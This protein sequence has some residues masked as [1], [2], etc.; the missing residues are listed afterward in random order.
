[1]SVRNRIYSPPHLTNYVEDESR[2][3][4]DRVTYYHAERARGGVGLIVMS[5][6]A[7]HPSGVAWGLQ[8][9]DER[10]I[11][12]LK[13][14][15]SMV[16]EHGSKIIQLIHTMGSNALHEYSRHAAWAPSPKK[17][18]MMTE[19]P[20]EMEGEEITHL[21]KR[22]GEVS[23]IIQEAGYDGIELQ[24]ALGLIH[25][26][27]SPLSNQR[28]DEYGGNLENRMRFVNEVINSI[29]K[30]C[31]REIVL[32]VKICADELTPGGITL[33]DAKEIARRLDATGKLDYLAVR[34]G[35]FNTLPI[36]IG[37]MNVPQG[38]AVP[39]GAAIKKV[40]T[41]PVFTQLRIKNPVHAEKIL[42]DGHADMVG[43]VRQLL[44]DPELPNKAQSGDLEGIR[45]CMAC[46]QGCMHRLFMN[47]PIECVQNPA[48]G[49]ERECG[50]GFI[51]IANGKKK[52]LIVGGGPAGLKCAEMAAQR[53]HRI[54]LYERENELGGQ[55][56]VAAK[57]FNRE[58]FR[59]VI[60]Y[61]EYRVKEL[62][63][64]VKSG[65]EATPEIVVE[66][67]PDAV[68][69]A[70]GSIPTMLS[71]PGE[72]QK[73]VFNVVQVLKGEVAV[74]ENV[75]VLDCGE[76]HWKYA[77]IV[78]YLAHKGHKVYA[79]TPWFFVGYSLPPIS[80]PTLYMRLYEKNVIINPLTSIK[81]I[82]GD[83]VTTFNVISKEEKLLENIDTVILATD[84][85]PDVDLYRKLKEKVKELY[86]IGDCV[87]PRKVDAAI[88]EGFNLG[89]IL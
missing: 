39:Y 71:L 7:L 75:V 12:H 52:L 56:H 76:G 50:S 70:T 44:C 31:G 26:F 43:M 77:S 69:I 19:V 46:N 87:A 13:R 73:N 51:T 61:L 3:W 25:N 48:S 20:H 16:H 18:F 28:K 22:Y 47:L 88:R 59:E 84:N 45:Y 55:V 15:T 40:V 67:A 80:V 38:M 89:R 72:E 21:I 58:E 79:L 37:D 33:D 82:S 36:F 78:E 32:G 5:E 9:V 62:K 64:E 66:E 8:V 34:I 63:V 83:I 85:Q 41:V 6:I 11:P 4:W 57:V 74:G 27:L 60:N 42:A 30:R 1:M 23:H 65:L 54:I 35:N 53:G 86:L 10:H 29:R 24:A 81:E 14:L 2:G 17:G 49:R 68:V